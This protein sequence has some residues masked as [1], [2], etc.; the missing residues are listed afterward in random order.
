MY[1]SNKLSLLFIACPKTGSTSIES[2][3]MDL[4][5]SGHK[6]K[7]ILDDREITSKDMHYGVIGHAHAWEYKKALGREKYNQLHTFGIVRHPFDKLISS[8]FY[9]KSK[10]IAYAFKNKGEKHLLKRKLKTLLSF[11]APRIL[12]ISIWA[13][14]FP[15]KTSYDYFHDKK[16]NRIVNYLGRTDYIDYDLDLILKEI[17]IETNLK[18][19]HIN[20]SKHKNQNHYFNNKW[21]RKYLSAKYAKDIY[22]YQSVEQ[23]INDL[24]PEMIKKESN[25]KL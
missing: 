12:P 24:K 5:P 23:E 14:L 10:P 4:E 15:M 22:L 17:G 6:F 25:I 8:Y 20:K 2:Y 9:S 7:I 1:F 18:I 13:L 19:P 16:G 3:L 21:I 11:I